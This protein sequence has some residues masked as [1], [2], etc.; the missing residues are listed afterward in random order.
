MVAKIS[1][2]AFNGVD[3]QSVNVEV[4]ISNGLPSFTIVGLPDKAV[5][6][7]KERVRAAL[8]ALGIAL[9]AKH[10][11]VNLAPADLTKEGSHY[12]L[13]IA[14]GLLAAMEVLPKQEME[15]YVVLGELS[16]DAGIRSVAG[17]LPAAIHASAND[18]SLICPEACGGEAAWA[19]DLEI[20]APKNLLQLINHIKG[21]QMLSQP[22]AR[23][24]EAAAQFGMP[25]LSQVKGQESAKRA[26]E[27]CA[28]GGHNLLFIGPPGAGK[29]LLASCLPGILPPLTPKEALEVSMIHSLA[30]TL[31]EGGLMKTRP[32]RDPH[33]SASLPALVGGGHRVRPGEISLAHR[34]VLF[35][36]ELPE[37]TRS[38]LESLRQP[39][40]T[41]TVMVAR[42]NNHVTYP[43]RFQLVAAMNPCRCGNLG[44]PDLECTKAPRCGS[45]YQAKLSGPL[46]DR[47]DL[48]VEVGAVALADLNQP[49]GETSKEVGARVAAARAIQQARY[50]AMGHPD[51]LT[52]AQANSDLLND[53]ANLEDAAQTMF[54]NAA[55]RMKLSAR[56]YHRLLRVARTI[57]DLD[58]GAAAITPNHVAEALSYRRLRN[59]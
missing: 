20:L 26:L 57:A 37:F 45:D 40:E 34:G 55:E 54:H 2:I 3:V 38:T 42:A 28:A 10:L 23:V 47:I 19:G 13:P 50:E 7:S 59:A 5:A 1:T 31:P 9:P 33:H 56:A 41:G 18:N 32:Y 11:T 35:L 46:L 52:N 39:L 17:V 49:G 22:G 4:Q 48:H 12:D 51:I 44:D 27:V 30:G 14:L 43:A 15:K 24:L 8:H 16:L 29:S 58:G 36:D 25:D 6:E 21:T 53:V